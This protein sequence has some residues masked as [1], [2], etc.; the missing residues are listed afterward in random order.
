MMI[1]KNLQKKQ[2]NQKMMENI[3][4]GKNKAAE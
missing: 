1:L 3:R 2:L 4:L